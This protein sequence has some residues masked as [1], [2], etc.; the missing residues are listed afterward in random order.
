[1]LVPIHG[2]QQPQAR[3]APGEVWHG[4]QTPA[5]EA[6]HA[7]HHC[8]TQLTSRVTARTRALLLAWLDGERDVDRAQCFAMSAGHVRQ[9]WG[10][11]TRAPLRDPHARFLTHRSQAICAMQAQ[12]ASN[13]KI[14]RSMGCDDKTVAKMLRGMKE[15]A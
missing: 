5:Y 8:L 13:A 10:L 3:L 7:L 15:G 12:G 2:A 11:G 6:R 9:E 14:A 4:P 1:M